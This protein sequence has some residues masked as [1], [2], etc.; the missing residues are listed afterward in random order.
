[1]R[2]SSQQ[3][4][5]SLRRP[6]R[7]ITEA[8][9]AAVA[10]GGFSFLQQ[11]AYAPGS[12]CVASGLMS[13]V[14]VLIPCSSSESLSELRGDLSGGLEND[15]VQLY[16]KRHLGVDMVNICS[17]GLPV[18]AKGYVGISLYSHCEGKE[19]NL[20]INSRATDLAQACGH[21]STVIYGDAFLSRYY[22]NEDEEWRRLDVHLSEVDPTSEWV[23]E[24]ASRN[25]GKNMSS[26]TT[27]GLTS[28]TL[29]NLLA[30]SNNSQSTVASA[31]TNTGDSDDKIQWS[32]TSDEIEVGQKPSNALFI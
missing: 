20:L 16:A 19:S 21:H 17:L 15:Q 1:M 3:R 18:P 12:L 11:N 8:R 26:Y 22:D 6:A 13:F 9:S 7:A 29:Q 5:K 32:Q 28:Q 30:N 31:P 23:Q 4:S 25:K 24:V 2:N 14:F 10:D 27:G